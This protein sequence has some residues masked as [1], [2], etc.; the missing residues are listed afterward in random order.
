M[1]RDHC[2]KEIVRPAATR[3]G[4]AYM[5]LKSMLDLKQP[6]QAMVTSAAWSTSTYA[7]TSEAKKVKQI[8]LDDRVFWESVAYSVKTTG[9]LFSVLRMTDAERMPAMG[10]LYPG[11]EKAKK[12]IKDALENDL[13]SYNEIIKTID[14]KWDKQLHRPIHSIACFLNPHFHYDDSWIADMRVKSG[15]YS[16]MERLVPDENERILVDLQ[17]DD[18]KNKKGM[19]GGFMAKSTAKLKAPG[20]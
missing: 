9:P 5:T 15:I 6:L 4:T 11:M 20:K 14:T 1:M 8:I 2:H 7:S 3:F 18:Y 13:A 10:F 16:A 17:L 19:F 12:D